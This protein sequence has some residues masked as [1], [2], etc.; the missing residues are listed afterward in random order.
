MPEE[1]HVTPFI[2]DDSK[3]KMRARIGAEGLKRNLGESIVYVDNPRHVGKLAYDERR[4]YYVE[5]A[6]DGKCRKIIR[7]ADEIKLPVSHPSCRTSMRRYKVSFALMDI[8]NEGMWGLRA[9]TS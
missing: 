5:G 2:L 8:I 9:G 6:L 7:E 1:Y 3:P 4:G